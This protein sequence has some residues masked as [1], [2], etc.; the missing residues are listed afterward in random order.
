[1]Q[2]L[3]LDTYNIHVGA[4]RDALPEVLNQQSFSQLFVLV[5]GRLGARVGQ[6][7]H[8]SLNGFDPLVQGP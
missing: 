4:V 6:G 7:A 1:M 5:D 8:L 2:T 3:A